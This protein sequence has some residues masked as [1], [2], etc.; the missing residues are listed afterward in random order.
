MGRNTH[1]WLHY[2]EKSNGMK[3]ETYR[4]DTNEREDTTSRAMRHMNSNQR[5]GGECVLREHTG[6]E[7]LG[8][9]SF[10]EVVRPPPGKCSINTP[11]INIFITL[12]RVNVRS[13]PTPFHSRALS[14][15]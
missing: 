14:N 7:A 13:R 12:L 5:Q 4:I 3:L 10:E 1:R 2:I 8:G 15:C 9:G 6:L 11:A